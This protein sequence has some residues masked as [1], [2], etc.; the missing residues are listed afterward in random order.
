MRRREKGT[1]HA[2]HCSRTSFIYTV[3]T[4]RISK[5][6]RRH[7]SNNNRAR[8]IT[9]TKSLNILKKDVRGINKNDSSNKDKIAAATTLPTV[10]TVIAPVDVGQSRKRFY[11]ENC[12]ASFSASVPLCVDGIGGAAQDP[13]AKSIKVLVASSACTAKSVL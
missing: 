2:V 9:P 12:Q 1:L 6:A 5:T 3:Q 13:A 4:E 10:T 7:C 11:P 8:T